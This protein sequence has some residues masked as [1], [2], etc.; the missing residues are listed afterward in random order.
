MTFAS[1]I[2]GCLIASIPACA[3]NFLIGGKMIR[4]LSLNAFAWVG[5]WVGQLFASWQGW[6]FLKTG[7]LLLGTDLLFTLIFIY[8]GYWLTNFQTINAK[9]K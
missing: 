3:F 4:L 7:P 6:T 9:K 5:F 1:I 2:F 8:L